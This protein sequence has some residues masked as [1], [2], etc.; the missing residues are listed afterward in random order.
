MS[1]TSTR[2]PVCKLHFAFVA[3]PSTG[4]TTKIAGHLRRHHK[5]VDFAEK[6]APLKQAIHPA[7]FRAKLQQNSTLSQAIAIAIGVF[8][9][10]DMQTYSV[11]ETPGFKHLI[12]ILEQ[13]YEMPSRLHLTTK[14]LP[15]MTMRRKNYLRAEKC[16][17]SGLNDRLLDLHNNTEIH[18]HHSTLHQYNR[19]F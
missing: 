7:S 17:F 15:S 16:L 6:T 11:V 8:A 10:S 19:L 3:H 2:K 5:D 18:N 4:N 9:A 12:S 14:L 1:T 13:R